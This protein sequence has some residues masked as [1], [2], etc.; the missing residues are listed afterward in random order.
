MGRFEVR[1]VGY[2]GQGVITLSKMIAHTSGIIE[3]YLV[4]QTE[5]YS[6][7]ARGGSAWA[8]LVIELDKDVEQ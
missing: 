6:A 1:I 3:D 8:E 7:E 2:G 4:T 5:A